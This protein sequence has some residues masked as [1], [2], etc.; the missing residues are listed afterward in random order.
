MS[1]ADRAAMLSA[2]GP[3]DSS[4][5]GSFAARSDSSDDAGSLGEDDDHDTYGIVSKNDLASRRA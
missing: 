1:A 4:L 2:S 3:P 5:M